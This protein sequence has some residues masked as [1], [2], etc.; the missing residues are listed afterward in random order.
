MRRARLS[1]L[2]LLLTSFASLVHAAGPRL[3]ATHWTVRDGLPVN[4]VNDLLQTRDGYL[5][6]STYDGLVRFDGLR[7]SVFNQSNTPSLPSNRVLSLRED[8]SGDLWVRTESRE[9]V[10]VADPLEGWERFGATGEGGHVLTLHMA[11]DGKPWIGTRTGV[12]RWNGRA[13]EPFAPAGS[14]TVGALFRGANDELWVHADTTIFHFGARGREAFRIPSTRANFIRAFYGLP[15]GRVLIGTRGGL[16]VP[17]RGT[18]RPVDWATLPDTL[19]VS[20]SEESARRGPVRVRELKFFYGR[21]PDGEVRAELA[22]SWVVGENGEVWRTQDNWLYRGDERVFQTRSEAARVLVDREGCVWLGTRSDGLYRFTPAVLSSVAPT[23]LDKPL[24]LYSLYEDR[25]GRMWF[26][27]YGAGAGVLRDGVAITSPL[28][29]LTR[30]FALCVAGRRDGTVL[31]GTFRGGLWSVREGTMTPYASE[32]LGRSDD[33]WLIHEDRSGALWVGTQRGLWRARGAE[34]TRFGTEAGLGSAWVRTCLERRGGELWFGTAGGGIAIWRD[35]RFETIREKQGLTAPSV[36]GMYEDE[37][38]VVWAGTEGQGLARI[39][40]AEGAPAANAHVSQVRAKDGLYDD[41]VHAVLGHHDELWASTNRGLFRVSRAALDAFAAGRQSRVFCNSYSEDDGMPNREANGG[42]QNAAVR[43][44]DGRLWFATQAGAVVVDPGLARRRVP[45]PPVVIEEV[46]AKGLRSSGRRGTVKLAADQRDFSISYAGLSLRASRDLR[47]RYR[48]LPGS[49]DWTE[50][51]DRRTAY[52]THIPPGRH[53]FEVAVSL[54]DGDWDGPV[55]RV[56]VDVAPHPWETPWFALLALAGA[57]YAAVWVQRRRERALVSRQR[58]LAAQVDA[59]TAELVREKHETERSRADAETARDLAQRSLGTIEAQARELR[60][61]NDARSRFF[62][63]VSHEFRTPLTLTIGPLEDLLEGRHG[64]LADSAR[65]PLEL[66]LRNSHRALRQVNQLLDMAKFEAGGMRLRVRALDLAAL[67]RD[68]TLAF[69]PLADRDGIALSCETDRGASADRFHGDAAL[70]EQ[71]LAN[72]L[73]NA[74][75]H[76]P[77]GGRVRVSVQ[78]DPAGTAPAFVHLRVADTGAGIAAADLEH[79]FK[80]FWQAEG[81]RAPGFPSTGIGLSLTQDIVHLHGGRIDVT[82]AP[83]EGST[84]TVSLPLG[85]THLA[86]DQLASAADDSPRNPAPAADWRAELEQAV[87]SE[88][89]AANVPPADGGERT[90]VLVVEDDPDVRAYLRG[91]LEPHYRVLEAPD[92]LSGLATAREALPDL[93]VS[94]V[95]MPG[96]DGFELCRT[97]KADPETE[98]VPVVLLT[99]RASLEHRI[100]GLEGGADDYL[101]KPFHARELLARVHNL[102]TLRRRLRERLEPRT[103]SPGEVRVASV[104][105]EFL[106][107][108]RAA[109]EASI[110]EEDF[111][112]GELADAV[113]MDRSQLYRRTMEAT[114]EGAE[115]LLKRYRLERSA[116]LLEQQAGN[117]GEIAYAVGFKSVSHFCKSFRDQF[118]VTPGAWAKGERGAA[119]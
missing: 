71:V 29:L 35:G 73:S 105:E 64:A 57:V 86:P 37:R 28:P 5:W 101:A 61:L 31:A 34:W 119:R 69:A 16:L 62:A 74:L 8:E 84:F 114:G 103:F 115:A 96:M 24:N 118:G 13:F 104:H 87:A 98:F 49:R 109:I 42:A 72:L 50:A 53:T 79:I 15:D 39:D 52:F 40:L 100:A 22:A 82:S 58:E 38:G 23:A 30:A 95:M 33:V 91:H 41:V 88:P 92:G 51:G 81:E 56:V 106:A 116:Q 97:L 90:T 43:S 12:Q 21:G 75:R 76:T 59:R 94:D 46:D 78:A 108:V 102:L 99:A 113:G 55:A 85:T 60:D 36:R 54:P 80:R 14:L 70:L 93:V 26:A 10:R 67:V 66:A 77:H 1:L 18:L 112:V 32:F 17:E 3:V 63:N 6:V 4:S 44:R 117:V 27:G 45:T 48:L 19:A 107:L 2:A 47:F 68:V 7:F 111:G 20:S 25:D 89:V 9:L 110:G 65:A 83:E 11:R